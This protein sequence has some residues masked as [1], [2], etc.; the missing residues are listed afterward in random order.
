ME[1]LPT[2]LIVDDEPRICSGLKRHLQTGYRVET[3]HSAREA[4]EK[5]SLPLF[6]IYLLDI[7]LP[8]SDGFR[9]MKGIFKYNPEAQ[10]VMMTGD[11]SV[12][13]AVKALK[14][15]ATDYLKK[16]FD[17]ED[18]EKT[19]RNVL[20]QKRLMAANRDMTRRL[21]HSER[22]YRYLIQNSP[23]MIYTLD[24]K[25]C[26]TFVNNAARDL[27]GYEA[28][29]LI[30][31]EYLV[32]F[33]D[34]DDT[35]ARWHFNERRTGARAT[36]GLQL[37]IKTGPISQVSRMGINGYADIELNATGV[38]RRED[39]GG[40]RTLVGTYGVVRDVSERKRLEKELI[41]A[42]KMQ[43]LG[44]LAGG[45]AHDFN[46]LLMGIQGNASLMLMDTR[47]GDP[48]YERLKNIEQHVQDGAAL[49]Q[50]LLGFVKGGSYEIRTININELVR[51]QN[52]MF[53]RTRKEIHLREDCEEDI[54][55]VDVDPVQI[56]QVLLNL[57]VNAW[58]A[59]P[60]GGTLE[61]RTRNLRLTAEDPILR[62]A[63][64]QPGCYIRISVADTGTGMDAG[65]L[66]RIFE[67]FFTTKKLGK[68]SGLGLSLAYGIIRNHGGL[69]RAFSKPGRGST[70]EILLPASDHPV[71]SRQKPVFRRRTG[72]EKILLV[73]DEPSVLSIFRDNLKQLGYRVVT[74]EDGRSA[75]EMFQKAR[76]P[77]D[78]VVLD[79]HM[80]GMKS[81]D[82]FD[83]LRRIDPEVRVL[84]ASGY[85]ADKSVQTLLR[86]GC[87][88]FIQKPST[89]EQL[90]SAIRGILDRCNSEA[91]GRK[92]R[93]SIS[94]SASIGPG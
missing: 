14:Q 76:T 53:G 4:L 32:L 9:L 25:G 68:G 74:A 3:A 22:R 88:G 6:D 47:I 70:F 7:G 26:F 83:A 17:P 33:E 2:I 34:P 63:E 23:D 16:P 71:E 77:V 21:Q 5:S 39:S 84:L 11:A 35:R 67:P 65:I 90:S 87:S 57:Y 18:L 61:I 54:W 24:A 27:F 40:R 41:H 75:I 36:S 81:C 31:K 19:L 49:T 85:S 69:I 56:E 42:K 62:T 20:K 8:D 51:K 59:M 79:M 91:P 10:V 37:R 92:S 89:I 55:A 50:Q 58:H 29:F 73:D 94:A 60:E 28:G 1:Q 80:P 30:G 15:G 43:A 46:N 44:N 93:Q 72:H 45:I 86:T 13:S 38:Y 12:D 66:Q 52:R 78:L 48:F 64:M 82:V